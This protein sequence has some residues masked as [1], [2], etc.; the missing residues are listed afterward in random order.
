MHGSAGL[1]MVRHLRAQVNRFGDP[2]ASASERAARAQLL[3]ESSRDTA[4]AVEV[5]RAIVPGLSVLDRAR[6][7]IPAPHGVSAEVRQQARERLDVRERLSE[8]RAELRALDTTADRPV[9]VA[10]S[11]S[12]GLGVAPL[13]RQHSVAWEWHSRQSPVVPGVVGGDAAAE[14]NASFPID[15]GAGSSVVIE[16][17]NPDEK[18]DL[19]VLAATMSLPVMEWTDRAGQ[20]L[21]D[22]ALRDLV[23]LAAEEFVGAGL[24]AAAGGTA[25]YASAATLDAAEGAAGGAGR[26]AAELL[27]VN[28][29]DWPTVRR[30]LASAWA[31]GPH[32]V[33]VVTPGA[34]AGTVTYTGPGAFW[35]LAS[36]VIED[37]DVHP[38]PKTM[39][40]VEVAI[41]RP[42]KL[43][44]RNAAAIR[45][46]TGV[47]A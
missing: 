35:L 21:L 37:E 9:I 10:D 38:S 25:A 46:V 17:V 44:V 12:T 43:F 4:E 11:T 20:E 14:V 24:E 15:P 47:G 18:F 19:S 31:A 33:P 26:G 39:G 5:A 16:N 2:D 27:I 1:E 40:G 22:N 36:E 34:T 45:T 3:V 6:Q 30:D 28:P 42:F 23:D 13:I 32:P 29:V 41:G 8:L 7:R